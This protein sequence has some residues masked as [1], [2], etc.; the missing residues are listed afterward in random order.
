M[1]SVDVSLLLDLSVLL[2]LLVVV[3]ESVSEL[4]L[5]KA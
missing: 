4:S 2:S 5:D 1:D 3:P